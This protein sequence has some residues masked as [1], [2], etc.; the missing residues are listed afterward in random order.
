MADYVLTQTGAEIQDILDNAILNT[1]GTITGN[2]EVNGN[3]TN[4]SVAVAKE[5]LLYYRNVTSIPSN[6]NLNNYTTYGTYAVRQDSVAQ[7]VT[8]IPAQEAGVLV[9]R[10]ALGGDGAYR[11]QTYL[12]YTGKAF[13]R[14][15]Q[16]GSFGAW[17]RFVTTSYLGSL[18]NITNIQEVAVS[19]ST[20]IANNATGTLTGTLSNTNGSGTWYFIP[21]YFNYGFATA[22]PTLSGTTLSV[23]VMNSSGASHTLN[24]R[25][26]AMRVNALS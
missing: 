17:Q 21:V 23:T 24:G 10:N 20:N 18:F 2:L 25:V 11:T 13:I 14:V 5:N 12:T 22:K 4:N 1:G 26:I 9:V 7:T 6:A 8:N 15:K 19:T 3:L 16:S